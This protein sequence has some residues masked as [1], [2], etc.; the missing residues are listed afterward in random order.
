MGYQRQIFIVDAFIV[1]ANGTF[2]HLTGY[3]KTFDSKNYQND[4]DRAQRR[5][6]G[7]MSETWGAMCKVDTRQIQTVTLMTVDGFMLEKKTSGAF[8]YQPEGET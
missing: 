1:D 3:P 7:D 2:N 4:L 6:E 8:D 5:A